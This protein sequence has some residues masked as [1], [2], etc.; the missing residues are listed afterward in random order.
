MDYNFVNYFGCSSTYGIL[1]NELEIINKTRD[2]I[3]IF[4]L[5]DLGF[6]GVGYLTDPV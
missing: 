2:P 6:S 4:W 5:Y 3:Y 1:N